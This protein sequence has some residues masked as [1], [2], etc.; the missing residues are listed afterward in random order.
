MTVEDYVNHCISSHE[1]ASRP[2]RPR[3]N[4]FK[5]PQHLIGGQQHQPGN[6]WKSR[7]RDQQQQAH[8][9]QYFLVSD[10]CDADLQEEY[11]PDPYYDAGNNNQIDILNLNHLKEKELRSVH[12]PI[13][14]YP[15]SLIQ[16]PVDGST[17]NK[18]I[19]EV[20]KQV[21]LL[22]NLIKMT[23]GGA[24]H[25]E[26]VSDDK[27]PTN[28]PPFSGH[29][30]MS[31]IPVHDLAHSADE[32]SMA[33]WKD[34][35]GQMKLGKIK[36]AKQM[37]RDS[38]WSIGSPARE[39]LWR[40]LCRHHSREKDFDDQYYWDTVKQIYGSTELSDSMTQLPAFID[41]N[42]KVS[43]SL[44]PRGVTVCER[45]ISLIS[46]NHPAITYAPA[47]YGLT[48]LL[49]HYMEEVDAYY[50]ISA[51][52][53]GSQS[54]FLSQTKI[55]YEAQWR[56]AMI[57]GK[58]HIRGAF[59]TLTK[60]GVPQE[61]IEEAFQNWIWWILSALPL[62]HT[63]RVIDCFL[64]EGS[65]VLLRIALAIFHVFV[66]TL[67]HDSS[68]V[69]SL[70]SRGLHETLYHFCQNI[71][72][73]PQ[74]LLKTAFGIRGFSKSEITKVV[75]QTE[76]ILKSQRTHGGAGGGT[77]QTN[78]PETPSLHRSLSLEGLPTSETQSNIQMMSH[79]LTIKEGSRSPAPRVRAMGQYPINN[80]KSGIVSKDE[81]LTLWSWL[82]MRMTMYQPTLIYTTEE[83][84]CSLTTFFQRTEKYEPTLLCIRTTNDNVF[85][86]YCSTA[87][88]QR[89]C[90]DEFGNWQTYFG[91]GE[92]F[93]FSLRPTVAK[94]QWVG[95]SR[96]HD[97]AA[98]SSVEHCAELF[99]HAD[100][101][102]I[103]IGGG[104]GQ[105]I[106]LDHEL[107]YGKTEP[108]QTFDNPPLAP[109]GDFEVKV[110]EVYSLANL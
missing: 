43:H 33:K 52:V 75:L 82:P 29:V 110:I 25:A 69:A 103:T 4:S 54:K 1:G 12:I 21:K 10:A 101:N 30:D 49:L 73:T 19:S 108:C 20:K 96:Q 109:N 46:F 13:S 41:S 97:D 94:Y 57:L 35:E 53:G 9:Q 64:F 6:H 39:N 100:S 79:T 78:L 47:L 31:R 92:T 11:T 44:S 88:A 99:M 105:G 2:H 85:G 77:G 34:I 86:A 98:L 22:G 45:I 93:L 76:M 28:P 18:R 17:K 59:S 95:I 42:H 74:K 36:E 68:M 24:A 23:V 3:L 58:K 67:T 27:T 89:H 65:K 84:G 56:A 106:M 8:Q 37:I 50:C 5:R 48:S 32:A 16:W 14:A 70:P 90:K 61:Q 40:E 62:T 107:R 72:I 81:L 91:T 26:A 15:K 51:L 80:V 87:W 102:M 60:F 66:K 55:A 83:H 63:V 7:K 71:Q 104:N 38:D